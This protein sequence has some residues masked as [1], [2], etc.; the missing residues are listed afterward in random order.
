[1]TFAIN[2]RRFLK[3][4]QNVSPC[5]FIGERMRKEFGGRLSRSHIVYVSISPRMLDLWKGI[6]HVP[7]GT[8]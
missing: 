3:S 4:A 7:P 8:F 6:L 1:L 5:R 2:V